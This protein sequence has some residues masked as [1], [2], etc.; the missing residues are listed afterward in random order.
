MVNLMIIGVDCD[1]VLTD[2]SA[3]IYEYGEKYFKRKPSNLDGYSTA[4]IFDCSD[5][6]E[7]RFGLRYFFTYCKKW[8]PRNG[9]AEIISKLNKDGHELYEITARKFVTMKNPLGWYS[10]LLY[11]QWLKKYGF[12]FKDIFYCS[13]SNA[14]ADKLIG[15]RKYSVD[16]MIDDKPEVALRLADNDVKVLLFDTRYNQNVNHSNIIRVYDWNDV[17]EKIVEIVKE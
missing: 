5:K 3:Y 11:E 2:M 13:E 6:D 16:L 9:A 7:F 1:G 4:E 10:R 12:E 17:Y 8:P 14:P 15:C